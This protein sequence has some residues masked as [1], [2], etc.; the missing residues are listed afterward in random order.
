MVHHSIAKELLAQR[1]RFLSGEQSEPETSWV[2]A[3]PFIHLGDHM[4]VKLMVSRNQYGHSFQ[5]DTTGGVH[6]IDRYS[7]HILYNDNKFTLVQ[8][9]KTTG[10]ILN[11]VHFRLI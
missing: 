4:E 7:D 11:K 8:V 5:L 1:D 10:L 2:F 6:V 3:L 9:D